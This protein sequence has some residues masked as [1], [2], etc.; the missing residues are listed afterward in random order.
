MIIRNA[1]IVFPDGIVEGCVQF[2]DSAGLIEQVGKTIGAQG[3]ETVDAQGAYLLAG[4]IDCH[5][6][7][8]DPGLTAKEDFFTGTTSALAGGVTT[9]IDMPNTNPPTTT[10]EGLKAKRAEAAKKSACDYAF[11]FGATNDNHAE[12]KGALL[13]KDVAGLKAFMGP[14]TGRMLLDSPGALL[15]H[16]RQARKPLCIHAEDAAVVAFYE[17]RFRNELGDFA[18]AEIHNK[19]RPPIAAAAAVQKALAILGEAKGRHLHVCHASTGEEAGEIR[20]AKAGGLHV[21]AE[22]APHHLFLTED[23]ARRLGNFAKVNPPL[24]SADDA[25]ALRQA[26]VEGVID[27][28]ASDHAPHL[29]A[30]KD[31][32]YWSA[33]SGMPGVETMLPLLINAAAKGELKLERIAEACCTSP[34]RIFALRHKGRIEKGKDADFVLLTL[35][36]TAV[37]DGGEMHSK[38]GWSAYD[39]MELRGG[40]LQVYLRGKLVREGNFVVAAAGGGRPAEVVT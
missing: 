24:R 35:D 32:D 3:E 15:E 37:V 23:D 19:A 28:V 13:E 31:G 40:I 34:S 4:L 20:K 21:T 36:G 30:E 10:M 25:A 5:T 16:L 22:A 2:D 1:R 17:E 14:S 7:M 6:H 11:F 39:G 26:L 9:I 38:C 29:K 18:G 33:P 8:R 12:A 27:C